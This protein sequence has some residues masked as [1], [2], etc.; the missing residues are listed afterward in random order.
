MFRFLIFGFAFIVS[1]VVVAAPP[2]V[3]EF[4]GRNNCPADTRVQESL[5]DLLAAHEDVILINCRSWYRKAETPADLAFSYKF[6][7]ERSKNYSKRLRE[8]SSVVVNGRWSANADNI[9]PAIKLARLDSVLPLS[10]S[11]DE[12]NNV[13]NINVS[14]VDKNL[15]GEV[16][17]YA[18]APSRGEQ[19][20]RLDPDLELTEELRTRMRSGESVPFVTPQEP[21]QFLFRPMA[22]R[23]YVGAWYGGASQI[24]YDLSELTMFTSF[25]VRPDLSY[26]VV[27]HEGDAFSPIIAT[28]QI[29]SVREQAYFMPKSEPLEIERISVPTTV[30]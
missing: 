24:R 3:V 6:C 26:V 28:G 30:P 12:R 23:A 25:A 8:G 13:L 16:Y 18:Y 21:K 5:R 11:L 15:Q 20:F 10:L 9:G 7:G 22:A 17:V 14:K 4:F 2:V 27:I 19:S 1:G 29:M